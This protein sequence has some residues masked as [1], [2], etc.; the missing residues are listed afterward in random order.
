MRLPRMKYGNALFIQK[1]FRIALQTLSILQA[2]LTQRL[3]GGDSTLCSLHLTRWRQTLFSVDEKPL[4]K[5][6]PC[7][8]VNNKYQ[9]ELQGRNKSNKT[10][11]YSIKLHDKRA[12]VKT[13]N[14][15]I[16][17]PSTGTSGW[18]MS[19][20]QSRCAVSRWFKIGNGAFR[21]CQSDEEVGRIRER[22]ICKYKWMAFPI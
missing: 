1:Y 12:R 14:D 15:I 20:L 11:A 21:G 22:Q 8:F 5:T 4:R 19:E 13:Q 3:W 6:S 16:T 18:L 17:V 9:N 2:K 7:V 10:T